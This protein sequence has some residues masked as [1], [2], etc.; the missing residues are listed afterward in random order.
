M[1]KGINSSGRYITISGGG[2][3]NYVNS[4]SGAQGVGNMR[5]NTSSQNMEVYDGTSWIRLNMDYTSV[6]LTPEAESLLDW[7]SKKRAEEFA[8]SAMLEKYPALRKAKD[9]FDLVLNTVKDDFN[10]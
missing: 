7:A 6:G 1:I 8:M 2:A 4:Y 3:S 10:E 9:N 5:Y